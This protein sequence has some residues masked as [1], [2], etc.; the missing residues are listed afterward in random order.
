ME[1]GF[2]DK[3]ED[4]AV[5]RIWSEKRQKEKGDNLSEGGKVHISS[6]FSILESR[7]QLLHFWKS[8]LGAH[9]R[10]LHHSVLFPEDPGAIGYAPQLVLRQYRLRQFIP[11]VQG[12]AQCEFAYKGDNYKKKNTISDGVK[13]STIMSLHQV[14]KLLE[15]KIKAN[16]WERKLQDAQVREDALKRELLES[17]DEKVSFRARVVE[18][19]RSLHQ[20]CSRNSVIELKASLIKIEELNTEE[21]EGQ[22]R[23]RDHIMNKALTQVWKVADHLQTLTVQANMLSLR[24]ELESD[25]GQELAWLLNKVKALSLGSNPEDSPTNPVVPNLDDMAKMKRAREELPKQLE[26]LCKWLKEKFRAMETTDYLYRVN[27]KELSLVPD[28]DSLIVSAAKWYNQLSRAK[29]NSWKDLAQ[30]FMKQYNH[31]TNMTPDRITLQNMEK[32]QNESFRQYAQRWNE[33]ASQ[34]QPPLLEK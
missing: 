10:R 18:L 30:A 27:A 23:D 34:V 3:V 15:E 4:N 20:Q 8:R 21:L 16:Q 26:D 1:K 28:L 6:S 13:E 33:V 5:V 9:R 22:T 19:E 32:K 25:R 24:Y 17:Q 7:L 31:V 12:L 11:A 14:K 29:I 2:L